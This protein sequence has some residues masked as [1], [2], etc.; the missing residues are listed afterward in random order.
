MRR[1]AD[2]DQPADLTASAST[3]KSFSNSWSKWRT[4]RSGRSGA[5]SFFRRYAK[6]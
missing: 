6:N 2:L 5:D 4:I 1:P 3:K